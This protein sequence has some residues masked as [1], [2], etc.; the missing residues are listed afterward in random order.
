MIAVVAW[1]LSFVSDAGRE[2]RRQR[3]V[4]LAAVDDAHARL[5]AVG[6][7]PSIADGLVSRALQDHPE[8]VD[9]FADALRARVDRFLAV[10]PPARLVEA[11]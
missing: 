6:C 7:P 8:D 11:S 9:A 10:A 2:E 5:N 1:V 3:Q 4:F